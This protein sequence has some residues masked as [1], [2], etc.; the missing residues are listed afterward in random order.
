MGDT[1]TPDFN[2]A[3]GYLIGFSSVVLLLW[4]FGADLSSFKLLGNEIYLKE[5]IQNVWMVLAGI[6]GYFWLRLY[7][8]TPKGSFRFDVPMHEL[9]DEALIKIVRFL[10]TRKMKAHILSEIHYNDEN[11]SVEVK[12]LT[13]FPSGVMTYHGKTTIQDRLQPDKLS[14]IRNYPH[15]YRNE[16]AYPRYVKYL[17]NGSEHSQVSGQAFIITPHRYIARF[18][19]VYV[20]IRGSIVSPWFFDHVTPF[21]LGGISICVALFNWWQINYPHA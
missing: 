15:Y 17:I 5:N 13:L 6:N 16:I 8:R 12:F 7:Q 11:S 9:Y 20:F 19:K 14:K 2:K 21:L 18:V 1:D 10:S 3:R 4:Y